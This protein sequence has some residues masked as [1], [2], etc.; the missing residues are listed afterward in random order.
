MS[1]MYL[2]NEKK[3]IFSWSNMREG[4]VGYK[5]YEVRDVGRR[6]SFNTK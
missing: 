2:S 1:L 4:K 6:K 3:M 5:E